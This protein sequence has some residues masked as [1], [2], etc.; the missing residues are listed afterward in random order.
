MHRNLSK[1]ASRVK[2]SVHYF[3][4]FILILTEA[5]DLL[6]FS[7]FPLAKNHFF[8]RLLT[9]DSK[10][11]PFEVRTRDPIRPQKGAAASFMV[12]ATSDM[13]GSLGILCVINCNEVK[14]LLHLAPV[15]QKLRKKTADVAY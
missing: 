9:S 2:R 5:V 6:I 8:K 13:H 11:H 3:F 12:T 4:I 7:F 10:K 15:I 1:H 14:G